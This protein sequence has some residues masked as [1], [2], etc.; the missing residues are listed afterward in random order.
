[1]QEEAPNYRKLR[2]L[3]AGVVSVAEKAQSN[4]SGEDREGERE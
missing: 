3:S 4:A 2:R 1:L